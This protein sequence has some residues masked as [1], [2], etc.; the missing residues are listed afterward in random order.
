MNR[1]FLSFNCL[2]IAIVQR[3]RQRSQWASFEKLASKLLGWCGKL[4]VKFCISVI[5]K[6]LIENKRKLFAEKKEKNAKHRDKS[7]KNA[8]IKSSHHQI[9]ETIYF[10][11]NRFE[12]E[13][14]N[15]KHTTS[16]DWPQ[17]M[18]IQLLKYLRKGF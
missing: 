7:L 18:G 15:D 13:L 12:F 9:S 10:T 16:F 14:E 11:R 6:T 17:I 5:Y 4:T 8:K 2:L 3:Q 1:L